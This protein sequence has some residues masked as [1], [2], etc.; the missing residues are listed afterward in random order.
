MCPCNIVLKLVI[1]LIGSSQFL[2]ATL[3]RPHL[4][5]QV[6][7][8]TNP[9]FVGTKDSI[10]QRIHYRKQIVQTQNKAKKNKF[11]NNKKASLAQNPHNLR[12]YLT[13]DT[14]SGILF[15]FYSLIS[16]LWK[17]FCYIM[18]YEFI[19]ISIFP[20]AKLMKIIIHRLEEFLSGPYHIIRKVKQFGDCCQNWKSCKMSY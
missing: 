17:Q 5:G 6:Q 19:D 14:A 3:I 12:K 1:S 8:G 7:F 10:A 2:N 15:P 4:E 20:L 13:A 11:K 16:S 9:D 18:S